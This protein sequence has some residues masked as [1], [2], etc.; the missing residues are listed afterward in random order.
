MAIWDEEFAKEWAVSP[1]I[2]TLVRQGVLE[3]TSWRQDVSPSFGAR[4]KDGSLLRLW[5]EHPNPHRRE[6]DSPYRYLLTVQKDFGDPIDR[7]IVET[8][9]IDLAL[10]QLVQTLEAEGQGPQWRLL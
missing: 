4:L 2:M 10:S 1:R 8:N 9:N 7:V 5:V 6:S 3:E